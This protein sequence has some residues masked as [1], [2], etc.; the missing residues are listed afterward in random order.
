M[1]GVQPLRLNHISV[2]TQRTYRCG[3]SIDEKPGAA[4]D[5]RRLTLKYLDGISVGED[6]WREQRQQL[7]QALLAERKLA[8]VLDLD[9]TLLHSKLN[10]ALTAE[11][12][13]GFSSLSTAALAS[14]AVQV[15]PFRQKFQTERD[16][17]AAQDKS[18][19]EQLRGSGDTADKATA[20][21]LHDLPD[22]QTK[23]RPGLEAFLKALAPLYRLFIYTM[24]D[25]LYAC[26]MASI[27]DPGGHLF[28]NRV[29][30]R[31][32]SNWAQH[33]KGLDKLGVV[34]AMAAVVD[35]TLGV[36]PDLP[37]CA[38]QAIG[39]GPCSASAVTAVRICRCVAARHAERA[40]RAALLLLPPHPAARAA[41]PQRQVAPRAWQRRVRGRGAAA[42]GGGRAARGTRA[43]LWGGRPGRQRYARGARIDTGK[44]S[45][46]HARRVQQ[47]AGP[48]FF[49]RPGSCVRKF[50]QAERHNGAHDRDGGR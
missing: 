6:Y 30:N 47:G 9:H 17:A 45:G 13:A 11:V 46:G 37:V 29:I 25:E 39:V 8:L 22:F 2:A 34:P 31:A 14:F 28:R 12:R 43:L 7:K 24:G 35:D 18:H 10:T 41:G 48:A 38:W 5:G 16:P 40:A 21:M 1:Y 23:L 44:D 19:L 49:F 36:L 32:D 42:G 15:L 26:A 50:A 4:P 20:A 3:A 33:Q 27:L